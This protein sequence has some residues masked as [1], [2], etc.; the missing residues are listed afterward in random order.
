MSHPT[1]ILWSVDAFSKGDEFERF[2][3]AAIK[4]FTKGKE[5]TIEPVYVIPPV[6]LNQYGIS[7]EDFRLRA[8]KHLEKK[9]KKCNI[10]GLLPY[11]ILVQESISL[12]KAVDALVD[13]AKKQK[14]ELIVATTHA[15]SGLPRFFLGS[16]SE[17][18]F[19]Q[20]H[21]PVLVLNPKGKKVTQFKNI[22]FAT[23]LSEKAKTTFTQVVSLAAS[24]KAKLYIFHQLEQ[25]FQY[26]SS[27]LYQT[28]LYDKYI[29]DI[30]AQERQ[31]VTALVDWAKAKGVK[32]EALVEEK[33]GYAAQS[34]LKTAKKK[35]IDMIA[36]ASQTGPV[37]TTLL[38]SV[39]RQII[40]SSDCPVW[41]I[42]P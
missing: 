18:L 28:P 6:Q 16:F 24:L 19:L 15:R 17:T 5:A 34:I 8:E 4:A 33:P 7:A 31:A 1:R 42:H 12:R 29:K 35:K 32:A 21:I 9:L 36:L 3:A 23:D 22:L 26:V 25:G 37:S 2:G 14:M 20:T 41:V 13:H 38:G 10:K 40:R 30:D 11:R 39:T 27:T